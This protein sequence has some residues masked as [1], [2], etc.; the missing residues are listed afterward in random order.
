MGLMVWVV[1]FIRYSGGREN[2][3]DVFRGGVIFR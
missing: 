2:A 3:T 1:G